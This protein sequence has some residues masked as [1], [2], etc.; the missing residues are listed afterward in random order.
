MSGKGNKPGG[1]GYGYGKVPRKNSLL[2]DLSSSLLG[3]SLFLYQMFSHHLI[4]ISSHA[5]VIVTHASVFS[6]PGSVD[7]EADQCSLLE[8]KGCAAIETGKHMSFEDK[9]RVGVESSRCFPS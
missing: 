9:G 6:Q 1:R 8:A 7:V 4:T 3:T 2:L 5:S